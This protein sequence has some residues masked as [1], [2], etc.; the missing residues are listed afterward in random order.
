MISINADHK[1]EL[2]LDDFKIISYPNGDPSFE[3]DWGWTGANPIVSWEGDSSHL[4]TN[5]TADAH[6]G[7]NAANLTAYLGPRTAVVGRPMYYQI[8]ENLYTDFW[9][10]LDAMP[11]GTI[12]YANYQFTF[13]GGYNLYYI[14]GSNENYNPSNTSNAAFYYVDEYN[15]TGIWNNLVRNIYDDMNAIF[16][17]GGWV[18]NYF[19]MRVYVS[20]SDQIAS[21]IFDDCY[22]V[23]DTTPPEIH[24]VSLENNP[25]YYEDAQ[26]DVSVSDELG[27]IQAVTVYYRNDSIW[28]SVN[29]LHVNGDIYRGF[30]PAGDFDTSYDYFVEATDSNGNSQIDDNTGSYY[31]YLIGDDIDPTI[32]IQDPAAGT[33]FGEILISVDCGDVGSGVNR[34]EFYDGTTLLITKY[35]GPYSYNWQTRTTTNGTHEIIVRVYDNNGNN[36]QD[37]VIININNDFDVP[38]LSNLMISPIKPE[39]NKPVNV[40]VVVN[41]YSELDFVH[42]I[43]RVND[44]AWEI[45]DMT[46]EEGYYFGVIPKTKINSIVEYYIEAS[47]TLGQ[48]STLGT[49][50]DPFSYQ[51]TMTFK[52]FMIRYGA[53]IGIGLIGSG[54]GIFFLVRFIKG[55]RVT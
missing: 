43:Y 44:G 16:G 41:D 14:I 53:V 4:Y 38:E 28:Y 46:S 48:V 17:P 35:T 37:D 10:R 36:A 22:F 30:I 8:P 24:F 25:T 23:L 50:I 11:T 33:Y 26:I 39:V 5:L 42:L 49:A 32:T 21:A 2:L 52:L 51:L 29:C 27:D 18:M 34:V 3:E 31:T 7:T 54:V 55:K 20:S 40:T 19:Q 1:V 12:A 15:T 9:W 47:D 6:T 45:V 13:E